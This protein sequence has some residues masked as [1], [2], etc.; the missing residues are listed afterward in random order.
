MIIEHCFG[1]T[2]VKVLSTGDAVTVLKIISIDQT[3]NVTRGMKVEAPP[4]AI[5]RWGFPFAQNQVQRPKRALGESVAFSG[6]H[7]GAFCY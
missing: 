5:S 3:A 2:L 1:G 6:A 7:P 4:T